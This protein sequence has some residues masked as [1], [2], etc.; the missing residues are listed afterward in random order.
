[1]R[2]W[3]LWR[4]RRT[5]APAAA[6]EAARADASEAAEGQGKRA[7]PEKLTDDEILDRVAEGVTSRRLSVPAILFLESSKPLSFVGSQ[8]LVFMEPFVKTIFTSASYDRFAALME[9]RD[10]YE[11]LIQKIEALE[12]SSRSK[13]RTKPKADGDDGRRQGD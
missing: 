8:F 6:P 12:A 10:N 7:S 5:R 4:F 9:D 2:R 1:V 3:R 11:R 13:A